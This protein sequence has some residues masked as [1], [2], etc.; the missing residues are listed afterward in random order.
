M[1]TLHLTDD[2]LLDLK[3]IRRYT[4][5]EF[6][7][8][9]TKNYMARLREGLKTLRAHPEIG[10]SIENLKP[11]FRCFQVEY[12][13]IFYKSSDKIIVVVAIL[14]E[15]QLPKRHLSQRKES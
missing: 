13:R 6:G 8:Q 7:T 9:Q 5:R 10:F 11:G 14:H 2:A 3:D 15:S 1:P 12:H 4:T